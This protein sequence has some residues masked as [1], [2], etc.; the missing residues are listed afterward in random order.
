VADAT[1]ANVF[2]IKNNI[3]CTPAIEEG[4]LPGITREIILNLAQKLKCETKVGSFSPEELLSADEAFL[5]NSLSGLIPVQEINETLIT[6]NAPGLITQNL[7]EA[8][9]H[10]IQSY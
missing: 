10:F 7:I 9:K 6:A 2:F 8:Y 1:V 4:A 5:T 3:L